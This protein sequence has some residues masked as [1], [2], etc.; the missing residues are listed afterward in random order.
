M[1]TATGGSCRPR[2]DRPRVAALAGATVLAACAAVAT[3]A[4]ASAAAPA[5]FPRV[6]GNTWVTHDNPSVGRLDSIPTITVDPKDPNRVIVAEGDFHAGTCQ[7]HVST[8]GGATFKL[9]PGQLLPKSPGFDRCTPNSA[10]IS[11]PMAWGPN[12]SLLVGLHAMPFN[13]SVPFTSRAP[14]SIVLSRSTDFGL[15]FQ[16]A[17]VRDNRPSKPKDNEGAWQPHIAADVAR[18]RVYVAWQRRNVPIPGFIDPSSPPDPD[19]ESRPALA[20]SIDGGKTFGPPIDLLYGQGD[21]TN[22]PALGNQ[23]LP[24]RRGPSI[25][26]APDGTVFALD[27]QAGRPEDGPDAPASQNLRTVLSAT[28][29]LGKTVQHYDVQA[30][31]DGTDYPE[32]AVAPTS[33]VPGY[34]L[35]MVT[36]D[37]ADG[38]AGQQQVHDIFMRRSTDGGKTWSPHVRLTDDPATN[39]AN[40]FD[41]AVSVAPNGRID[42]A[43]YD[44][45]NDDGHMLIDVYATYSNDGGVTWAPN[46]RVTDRAADRRPGFFVDGGA[47]RGPVGITSDNY[48]AHYAW[49]DTRNATDALPVQDIYAGSIQ[50]RALPGPKNHNGL[51]VLGAVGGGLVATAFVLLLLSAVTGRRRSAVPGE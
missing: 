18:N 27:T 45:R 33:G 38:V 36:E 41:P 9:A 50:F 24:T 28:S 21:L 20:V 35:L 5:S 37:Y 39:F 4:G 7:V 47:V 15:S 51:L 3:P 31:T 19:F 49:E 6:V 25:A 43:W 46:V 42:V 34:T 13:A 11:Y 2:R 16:S 22:I 23:A 8:D 12:D 29:D 44:F 48:A 26:V 17:V 32:L 1:T 14:T 30:N 10:G 40:K